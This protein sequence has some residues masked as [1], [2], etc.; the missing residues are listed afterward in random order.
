MNEKR[1]AETFKNLT[2]TTVY[3]VTGVACEMNHIVVFKC[4]QI[5]ARQS[6]IFS[7]ISK[8]VDFLYHKK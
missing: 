5:K 3:C 7:S 2:L 8:S 6:G 4:L 1:V